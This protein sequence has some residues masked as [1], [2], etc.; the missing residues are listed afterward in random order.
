MVKHPNFGFNQ[1]HVDVLSDDAQ[2]DKV[3]KV[4]VGKKA[5]TN[6]DITPLFCACI[7]PNPKYIRALLEVGPDNGMV[8]SDLRRACHYAAACESEEPLQAIIQAGF[9]L[10]DVDNQKMNCLHIA[11]MTGRAE[12]ARVIL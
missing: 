5:N 6:K 7:N 1:L 4:S 9:S 2:I 12:N 8:D 3:L 10:N 11:A